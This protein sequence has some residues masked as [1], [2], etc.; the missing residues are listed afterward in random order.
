MSAAPRT[1]KENSPIVSPFT[2]TID[3]REQAPYGFTGIIADAAQHGRPITVPIE[4]A[5][6]RSGDYSIAG[7]HDLVAVERK[8]LADLYSTLGQGR[9]RFQREHE[10]LAE[11]AFAAVV[12][13]ADWETILKHPPERSKLLPKTV[14]RTMVSWQ[15]KYGVPWLAMNG[16]RL[17]ELTTFQI[18]SKFYSQQQE[19][20]G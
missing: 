4:F 11:F 1:D 16:R 7:M 3:S 20:L 14:H 10:R 8:S 18:L 13:E 5:T 15:I 2:V 12:I 6:L 17:A 19:R 9:E